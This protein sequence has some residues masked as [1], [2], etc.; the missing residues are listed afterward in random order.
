M[1]QDYTHI[2]VVLDASGSM[3]GMVSDVKGSLLKFANEQRAALVSGEKISVDAY[4]FGSEVRLMFHDASLD[5]LTKLVDA[6]DANM[7]CTALYDAVCMGIDDLGKFFAALP[8]ERRP[9]DVL[10]VIVTDGYENASKKFNNPDVQSRIKLQSET[11]NW[12][13]L[14]LASGIDSEAAARDIGI[15]A[16]QPC[17]ADSVCDFDCRFAKEQIN[18]KAAAQMG[19]IRQERQARRN[20]DGN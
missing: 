15:D 9:E 2:C 12:K 13:F 10:F 1:Q 5:E 8:E 17:F 7:G 4:K 3:S 20:K 11:Y 6:Y 14:F 16:S 18:S 19:R